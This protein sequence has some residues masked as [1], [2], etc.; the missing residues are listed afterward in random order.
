MVKV[1]PVNTMKVCG[2]SGGKAPHVLKIGDRRRWV[3]SFVA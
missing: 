2:G 1:D 3:D